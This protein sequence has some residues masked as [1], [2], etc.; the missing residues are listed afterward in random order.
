MTPNLTHTKC[1]DSI[2]LQKIVGYY[3]NYV[4][5]VPTVSS[6]W[7]FWDQLEPF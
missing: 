6:W 3:G 5:F 7:D 4:P 1:P 2:E